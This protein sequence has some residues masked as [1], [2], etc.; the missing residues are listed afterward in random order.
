M[1]RTSRYQCETKK[2]CKPSSSYFLSWRRRRD[3]FVSCDLVMHCLISLCILLA[4]TSTSLVN[5][6]VTVTGSGG[7]SS[8]RIHLDLADGGYKGIVVKIDKEVP[9]KHCPK[10]LANIKVSYFISNYFSYWIFIFEDTPYTFKLIWYEDWHPIYHSAS[11]L[12][13]CMFYSNLMT[14]L[15]RWC[16]LSTS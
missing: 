6:K 15:T 1:A 4:I 11:K 2:K 5:A 12:Y 3:G 10:I 16:T 7:Y 9:E 13:I 8:R 14:F